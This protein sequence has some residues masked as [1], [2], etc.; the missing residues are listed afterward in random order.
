MTAR[1]PSDAALVPQPI[2]YIERTH[3]WYAAL[4]IGTPYRY[5]SFAEVPFTALQKPLADCRVA[6][7]TTAAPYRPDKGEQGAG[8]PY[9]AAAKFYAV[10]AL[11]STLDHDL[12][13]S[14]VAIDR[15]HI[16]DDSGTWFPLPALRR[17]LQRGRIGAD[18]AACARRADQPQPAPHAGGRCARAAGALPRRC[19]GRGRAGAELPG[20]P[21]DD[22]AGG[23]AARSRRH[24]HGD[25]G[26]GQG[27]RRTRGRAAAAVQRRA[28][29]Q[30]GGVAA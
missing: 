11:D 12:R 26:R 20:V 8:A 4:G 16:S 25:H 14:H 18:R 23:A 21:P 10:Y 19:G 17:A 7:L 3:A 28:A 30:C 13:V 2:R 27:H 9:N 29:G 24:R 22:G 1:D 15:A 5:A 6:L